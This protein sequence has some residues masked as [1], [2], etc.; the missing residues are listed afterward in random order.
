MKAESFP[1]KTFEEANF[2][3]GLVLLFFIR[4]THSMLLA[5]DRLINNLYSIMTKPTTITIYYANPPKK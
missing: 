5:K 2:Y 4:I 3:I 1:G